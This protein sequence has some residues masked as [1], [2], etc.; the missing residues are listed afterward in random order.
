M[1][2]KCNVAAWAKSV[3]T[4]TVAASMR[5]K[6]N[7]L[8]LILS[9]SHVAA[10]LTT[11]NPKYRQIVPIPSPS[12][13]QPCRGV[14]VQDFSNPGRFQEENRNYSTWVPCIST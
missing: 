4:D 2:G 6:P 14:S 12:F 1:V 3:F 5:Y 10:V 13:I 11:H 8:P 7:Q 9:A